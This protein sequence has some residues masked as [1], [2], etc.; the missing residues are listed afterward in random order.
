MNYGLW[1]AKICIYICSSS[2]A[3][4]LVWEKHLTKYRYDAK[5]T[6]STSYVH[7]PTNTKTETKKETSL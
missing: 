4:Q 2:N 7:D 6:Y 3:S 5:I 1:H